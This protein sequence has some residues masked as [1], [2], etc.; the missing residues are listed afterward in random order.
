[1]AK[2]GK[3]NINVDINT[4]S[5][6]SVFFH[7]FIISILSLFGFNFKAI[8]FVLLPISKNFSIDMQY[9]FLFFIVSPKFSTTSLSQL[10]SMSWSRYF[11]LNHK[12]G[13]NQYRQ[14]TMFIMWLSRI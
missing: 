10:I 13:L 12:S 2:A 7:C 8:L 4:T 11:K 3:Q 6:V 14:A 9:S 1:L 5:P